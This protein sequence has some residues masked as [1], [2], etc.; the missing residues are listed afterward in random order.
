MHVPPYKYAT[1]N[2]IK[3]QRSSLH[4]KLKLYSFFPPQWEEQTFGLIS[5][6][7]ANFSLNLDRAIEESNSSN[8]ENIVFSPLALSATLSLVLLASNGETFNE[9]A[10]ILGF[11]IIHDVYHDSELVHKIVGLAN[12]EMIEGLADDPDGPKA[13]LSLG[14][15]LKSGYLIR[16]E[17]QSISREFYRGDVVSL[18][19]ER[20][21]QEAQQVINNWV[22]EKSE[23]KIE[24]ILDEVPSPLTKAI[25]TSVLYFNGEWDQH[26]I[27]GIT[28][29][30][31]FKIDE[32][33]AVWVDMMYNDGRFP[34]YN[35]PK[36]K[37]K[38]IGF[39][40]K[41]NQ[42]SMYAILPDEPGAAALRNLK[43]RLNASDLE[44][45][46]GKMQNRSCL[47]AFPR[48][49]LSSDLNLERALK[50]MGLESLFDPSSADLG[51][52]SQGNPLG[53]DVRASRYE[54]PFEQ[55]HCL[56][57]RLDPSFVAYLRSNLP[58]V[59]L[60]ELR[61]AANL[62]NPGLF[63][64]SLLHRVRMRVNEEGTEAAAATAIEF[65]DKILPDERFKADRP[66]L[67]AIRHAPTKSLMFWAT[68]N[69]P[70]P[71][72]TQPP[73]KL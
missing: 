60:D 25:I 26:F 21:S 4:E 20:H 58:D 59:R 18:D 55:D 28:Q 53:D 17:F 14:L 52:L 31:E 15:F 35:D 6:A 66:F 3:P 51:M 8:D 2:F 5:R 63:A 57:R 70:T 37:V 50:R 24:S 22:Y 12:Q 39:P 13:R 1:E 71:F 23:G 16:D 34:F 48:M 19:F 45:L 69:K 32:N 72:Y 47:V 62:V 61:R 33:R 29:K 38:I 27:D 44:E 10:K 54:S 42:V 49:N 68:I 9:L 46:I 56:A 36:L 43:R 65:I 67:L 11:E 41:N 7:I 30:V 64:D 73:P 40:Y